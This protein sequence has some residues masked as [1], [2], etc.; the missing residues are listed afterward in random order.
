MAFRGTV[1]S[2]MADLL[3]DALIIPVEDGVHLGFLGNAR[4]MA[5]N[6]S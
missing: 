5:N 2:E 3:T 6:I 4:D 1:P